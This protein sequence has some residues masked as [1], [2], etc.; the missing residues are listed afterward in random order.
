MLIFTQCSTEKNRWIN[1]SFHN[2]T[3]KYNG[4]FNAN[5][6]IKESRN[7]FKAAHQED[8]NKILPIYV[9]ANDEE[10]KTL[11]PAM[12]TAIKKCALV[13][14]KHAMPEKKVG[15]HSNTEWCKWIDN[16][17]MVIGQAN[18]YKRDFV[19]ALSMF[20]YVEEK[21]EHDISFFDAR[22]WSAKTHLE[23]G[24]YEK[25]GKFLKKLNEEVEKQEEAKSK[26]GKEK[27]E[28]DSK[29]V[30]KVN[31]RF[32]VTRKSGPKGRSKKKDK[33]D[34]E[35]KEPA[36]FPK[37]MTL[38]VHVVNADYHLKQEQYGKAIDRIEKALK[39]KPKKELKT[40]LYFILGQI[41]QKQ[42]RVEEAGKAYS[43]VIQL[44]PEYEMTFYAKIN[45]AL[46]GGASNSEL[47]DELISMAK[48]EKNIDYLDQIFYALGEIEFKEGNKP[49]ALAYYEKSAEASTSNI[50]QK[51]KTYLRLANI[52]FEDKNYPKA[53]AYFDSTS[54]VVPES[55]PE[56]LAIQQKNK[57]LT[58]LIKN[59]KIV[60]LEDSLQKVSA[61]SEEDQL[62][63]VEKIIEDL[64]AEEE[65]KKQEALQK[66]I[67]DALKESQSGEKGGKFWAFNPQQKQ[68]GFVEFKQTW[69]D[70]QNE[71]NWRRKNKGSASFDPQNPDVAD[72]SGDYTGEK[73]EPETYLKNILK[74]KEDFEKSNERIMEALYKLGS[75]YKD[76]LK[77]Y[78]ES[79]ENYNELAMR[80]PKG[81]MV[82][83]SLYQLY[84]LGKDYSG[85]SSETYKAKILA[86]HPNSEYA[87]FMSN[88]NYKKEKLEAE[89]KEKKRYAEVYKL[90]QY[91]N[92]PEV[93]SRCNQSID[94]PNAQEF[95]CK[96]L[97]LKAAAIG[98]TLSMEENSKPVLEALTRVVNECKGSDVAAKAQQAIDIINKNAPQEINN[99]VED[100]SKYLVNNEARHLFMYMVPQGAA[101][102]KIKTAVSNFNS[103]YFSNKALKVSGNILQGKGQL[104][105][106][107]SFLN[108]AEAMDYLTAF[109]VNKDQVKNYTGGEY[110]VISIKNFQVL[111]IEKDLEA[112]NS[113]YQ[114]NYGQ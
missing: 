34:K 76:E 14:K 68:Q 24:E 100:K 75:L 9:Y 91:G 49:E 42:G 103:A 4:Y 107:K 10:S 58:E 67:D 84:L 47:K 11:Y 70:R 22:L 74:S 80:Y 57:T 97:Y 33:K 79:V 13:V 38:H 53:Q 5:E 93:I 3:A 110:Y 18:F 17:W 94:D 114:E 72:G 78:P 39:A 69:G 87:K 40:R 82:P 27:D 59:I 98:K 105:L 95:R 46:S 66:Q 37:K 2:T 1:R 32:K 106:V 112:Y 43:K 21:Y 104:V 56:Y 19:K 52:Y 26:K 86:N 108:K 41:Y 16:N 111:M 44:N 28:A 64:K 77:D 25:A 30:K 92:Y 60:A 88:P 48:D 96:Y 89:S 50:D 8:Y 29:G 109:K 101:A 55:H 71:D 90:F 12:D 54:N 45:R 20:E 102:N 31:E 99:T 83:A 73:Y 51:T 36:K 23:L 7:T 62:I 35:D 65:R 6:L 63:L 15:E 61:M 85:I 81:E 113:F